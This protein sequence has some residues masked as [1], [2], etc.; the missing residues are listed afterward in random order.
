MFAAASLFAAGAAVF[1]YARKIEPRKYKLET[2]RIITGDG[3]AWRSRGGNGNHTAGEERVERRLF[4]IL[5]LSDLHLSKPESHK[6]DFIRKITDAE[7]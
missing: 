2:V 5:H 1:Y 3:N 4:K 7:F 6:I